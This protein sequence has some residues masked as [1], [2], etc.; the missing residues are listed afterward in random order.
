MSASSS[1]SVNA[2]IPVSGVQ[3]AYPSSGPLPLVAGS[4]GYQYRA[5]TGAV[6]TPIPAASVNLTQLYL[7]IGT[8]GAGIP[9]GTYIVFSDA[10]VNDIVGDLNSF[11]RIVDSATGLVTIIQ[12]A[13]SY[14]GALAQFQS[15][16]PSLVFT[17]T[18]DFIVQSFLNTGSAG[19]SGTPEDV[20][21]LQ[22]VR[23]A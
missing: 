8:I 5:T 16:Q 20:G 23:I 12:G 1:T 21:S 3:Y 10:V 19:G 6:V 13:G 18:Q 15:M 14:Q 2:P 17:S 22:V 4:L 7:Q 11:I 9:A